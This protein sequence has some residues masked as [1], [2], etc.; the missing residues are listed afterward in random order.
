MKL[1]DIYDEYRN[2]CHES[3]M[4]PCRKGTFRERLS[5]QGIK[6]D[7][8]RIGNIVYVQKAPME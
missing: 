2:F 3:G 5:A 4:H 8:N 7:K 6:S 1:K